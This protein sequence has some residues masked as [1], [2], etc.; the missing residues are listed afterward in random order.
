MVSTW[1]NQAFLERFVSDRIGDDAEAYRI[2]CN[3]VSAKI[4]NV[5]EMCSAEIMDCCERN[6]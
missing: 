5:L 6:L 2:M 4:V 3:V 1:K